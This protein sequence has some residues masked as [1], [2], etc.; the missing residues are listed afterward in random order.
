MLSN[1]Q[2]K[3]INLHLEHSQAILRAKG[4]HASL[5][6]TAD[7]IARLESLIFKAKEAKQTNGDEFRSDTAADQEPDPT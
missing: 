6:Q 5:Q 2:V 3:L 1:E 7:T 4:L